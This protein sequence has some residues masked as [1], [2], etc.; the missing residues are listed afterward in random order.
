MPLYTFRN[1]DTEE[2][3]E[4]TLRISDYDSYLASNPN[5]ERYIDSV[6]GIVGGVGSVRTDNGFKEVLSKVA[7][8]H[9]NSAL[10][11]KT[12]SRTSSQVKTDNV[13]RKHGILT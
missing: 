1:K 3:F 5:I 12:I 11:N 7:E 9:P 10:A 13:K 6:P 8:A 2:I 4:L